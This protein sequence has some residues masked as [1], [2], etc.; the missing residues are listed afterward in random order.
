METPYYQYDLGLL[1]R[2]LQHLV[3]ESN[4]Y[5]IHYALKANTDKQI[6]KIIASYGLGAD[7]VSG[8]EIIH[9]IDC[10]FN[11][12]KIVFLIEI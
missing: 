7:C 9:A 4:D 1:E 10:G 11:P 5:V 8:N 2:T 6:N 12:N 3:F